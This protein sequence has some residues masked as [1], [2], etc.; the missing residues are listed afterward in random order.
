MISCSQR[1]SNI[2]A[3]L[4]LQSEIAS[5][6]PGIFDFLREGLNRLLAGTSNRLIPLW[7]IVPLM[8][9]YGIA[10]YSIMSLAD[11][12]VMLSIRTEIMEA[13]VRTF[14]L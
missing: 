7:R 13:K 8:L 12:T 4:I 3:H 1:V 10:H 11:Y 9:F 6:R 2:Y 5:E 14:F